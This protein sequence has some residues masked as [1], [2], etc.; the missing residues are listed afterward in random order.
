MY[1]FNINVPALLDREV[2]LRLYSPD[3]VNIKALVI[4]PATK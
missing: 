3:I 1:R 4:R 2:I